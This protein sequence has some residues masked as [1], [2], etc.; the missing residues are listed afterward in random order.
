MNKFNKVIFWCEFPKE[1][2]WKKFN[3]IINFKISVF[4]AAKSK[5]E[6]FYWKSKIK[7]KYVDVGVW[8]ILSKKDGYWFSGFCSKKSID[9][10]FYF[11]D[12]KIKID[13]EPPIIDIKYNIYNILKFYGRLLLT[14][15]SKNND[16]LN[17]RIIKLDK[18]SEIILSGLPLP[19]FISKIYGDS[20]KNNGN[21]YRN[22]FIYSTL[23]PKF[24]SPLTNI[25]YTWF[26]KKSIRIYKEK[27]MF[28][29]GCIGHGIFYSEP[30]YKNINEFDKDMKFLLKNNVKNIVIFELA[31]LMNRDNPEL[32]LDK[33]KSY[34]S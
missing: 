26:I 20:L 33:I 29:I 4:I 2:D 16:Y 3:K 25:Y 12:L 34:K 9:K 11:K 32:W 7:S 10:L 21:F 19:S 24:L 23:M 18:N 27:V 31:G 22:Y 5:K 17:E 15:K 14:K 28:A 6:F 8:P 30:I 1:V 13:L